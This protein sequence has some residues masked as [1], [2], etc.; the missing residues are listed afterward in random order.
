[1]ENKI[2]NIQGNKILPM[3]IVFVK[4]KI[5]IKIAKSGKKYFGP[6]K[7]KVAA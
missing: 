3:L 5:K 6:I 1:M 2:T 7:T 4:T